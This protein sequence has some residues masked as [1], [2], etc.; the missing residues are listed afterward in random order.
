MTDRNIPAKVAIRIKASQVDQPKVVTAEGNN[1]TL[2]HPKFEAKKYQFDSVFGQDSTNGKIF[3]DFISPRV[4]QVFNGQ[5]VVVLCYGPE[6]AG[7]T[8]TLF[9]DV[10]ESEGI[11]GM[12]AE[13]LFNKLANTSVSPC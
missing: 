10:A 4:D 13:A 3:D 7:K 11:I 6:Q 2:T 9:G 8:H 1:I 12:A 5:N